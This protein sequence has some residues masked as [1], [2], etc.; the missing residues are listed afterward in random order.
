[1]IHFSDADQDG[2]EIFAINVNLIPDASMDTAMDLHGS[3]SVIP[4][5]EEYF[6][7]KVNP[8]FK[9]KY[10]SPFLLTAI[11]SSRRPSSISLTIISLSSP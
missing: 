11:K 8:F 4:I 7:I 6:A 3:V 10:Q 1:M 5:G 9:H 2:E